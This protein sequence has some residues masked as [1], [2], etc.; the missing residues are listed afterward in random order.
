MC[1]VVLF[2]LELARYFGMSF[3]PLY[4]LSLKCHKQDVFPTNQNKIK[5]NKQRNNNEA[6]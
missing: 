1:A 3:L 2:Y 4:F 6:V 5:I